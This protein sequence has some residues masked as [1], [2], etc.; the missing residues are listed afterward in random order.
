MRVFCSGPKRAVGGFRR[1]CLCRRS[2]RTGRIDS[3]RRALGVGKRFVSRLL[4]SN[5]GVGLFYAYRGG[6]LVCRIGPVCRA[7]RFYDGFYCDQQRIT[8]FAHLSCQRLQPDIKRD[9]LGDARPCHQLQRVSHSRRAGPRRADDRMAGGV[10]RVTMGRRE[11]RDYNVDHRA[12]PHAVH[13]SRDRGGGSRI[14]EGI[15]HDCAYPSVR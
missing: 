14:A 11:K 2:G 4:R 8:S 10:V 1:W 7:D 5:A 3:C 12:R 15:S 6:K 9:R 13:R